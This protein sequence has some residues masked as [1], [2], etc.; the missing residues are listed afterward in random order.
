LPSRNS[1][2]DAAFEKEGTREGKEGSSLAISS[3]RVAAESRSTRGLAAA[4]LAAA[5]IEALSPMARH[6]SV[7]A[8][9]IGS[10]D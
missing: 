5:G 8:E 6:R 7:E 2:L 3:A 1:R 9:L 4:K 10:Q